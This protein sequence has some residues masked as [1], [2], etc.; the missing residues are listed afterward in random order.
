VTKVTYKVIIHAGQTLHKSAVTE[1][2]RKEK[3]RKN[4]NACL[5]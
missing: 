1:M 2:F 5:I 4:I 3:E